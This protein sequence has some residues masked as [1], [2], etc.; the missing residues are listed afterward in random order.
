MPATLRSTLDRLARLLSLTVPPL[1]AWRVES[2]QPLVSVKLVSAGTFRTLLVAVALQDH[3]A[4]ID[5]L[6]AGKV[7]VPPA[8]ASNWV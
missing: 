8:R 6:Q 4:G 7:T 2:V 1:E 3:G 5:R